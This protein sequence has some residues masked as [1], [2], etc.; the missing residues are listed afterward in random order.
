MR[1]IQKLGG[2]RRTDQIFC[3]DPRHER[4]LRMS[5]FKP[6]VVIV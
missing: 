2:F 5:E 3:V 4:I 1:E 6:E